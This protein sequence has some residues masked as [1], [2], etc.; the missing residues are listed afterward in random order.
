MDHLT[1]ERHEPT[2]ETRQMKQNSGGSPS[3]P[4]NEEDPDT[5]FGSTSVIRVPLH[6]H[7]M[8]DELE[9]YRERLANSKR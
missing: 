2:M 1:T 8:K 9:E 5:G 3:K 4:I 7:R 6:D